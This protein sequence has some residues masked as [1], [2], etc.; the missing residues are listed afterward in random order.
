MVNVIV[1]I[2][3]NGA[4]FVKILD[5]LSNISSVHVILGVVESE[6]SVVSHLADGENISYHVFENG[7]NREEIINSL[8]AYIEEGSVMIM[9]RPIKMEEFNRFI[10]QRKDIVTCE[11]KMGRIKAFFFMIW[12]NILKLFLGVRLYEG[13]TSV[14]YF[15]E[16][17]SAVLAQSTNLSYSSRVDRWRGVEHGVVDAGE[18]FVKTDIDKKANFK[19]ILTASVSVVVAII[20]SVIVCLFAKMSIIVGLLIAC[21]DI[22]AL[23][24]AV[25]MAVMIVFNNMVGSKKFKYASEVE[26]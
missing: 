1:P 7:A 5:K 13:D 17:I 4:G 20:V 16:E 9:R 3:K 6:A 2:A 23:A 19:Y 21:L 12:Q 26:E 15:G 11:R 25:I 22:I 18:E 24:V 14:I 10:S 8:Q